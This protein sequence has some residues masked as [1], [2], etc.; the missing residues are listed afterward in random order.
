[1]RY[2]P[3]AR[4]VFLVTLAVATIGCLEPEETG[5]AR[6]NSPAAAGAPAQPLS[7]P[8]LESATVVEAGTADLTDLRMM[9]LGEGLAAGN[10]RIEPNDPSV[11]PA[12]RLIVDGN[13]ESLIK[14]NVINPLVITIDLAEEISLAAVRVYPVGSP[15]D[16]LV[17]A[18]P[19]GPRYMLRGV[20]ERA[21]SQLDLPE[22]VTTS[23]VRLEVLRLKRDD[24]VH[25]NEVELYSAASP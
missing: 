6:G 19:G 16:W 21:W 14:S 1:M 15:Y 11:I 17:E 4:I 9:D 13:V 3:V 7:R 23:I 25:L 18:L 22:A 5:G 20:P 10:V 24:Y 12:V 2:V 8:K